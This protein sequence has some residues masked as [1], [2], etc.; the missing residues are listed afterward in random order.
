MNRIAVGLSLENQLAGYQGS[1]DQTS[2]G[3]GS[4]NGDKK[5]KGKATKG[6]RGNPPRS[7]GLDWR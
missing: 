4:E 1:G 6:G 2:W 7:E 3:Q 5:G